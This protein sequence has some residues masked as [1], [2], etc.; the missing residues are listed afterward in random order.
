MSFPKIIVSCVFFGSCLLATHTL[1]AET[2]GSLKTDPSPYIR[3]HADDPIHW[4]VISQKVLQEAQQ[5]NRPV[6]ISSGYHACYWCYRMKIDTFSNKQLASIIND[7]F[8]PVLIDREV[9]PFIDQ[10][11]QAFMEEQRGFGGWPLTVILTPQG[12]PVAGFT[13]LGAESFSQVLNQFSDEWKTDSAKIKQLAET[14]TEAR[15]KKALQQDQLL[16]HIDYQKLLLNF[17]RQISGAAD[18]LHGGFGDKE[19][20]PHVPQLNALLDI[21]SL[22]PDPSLRKFLQLTLDSLLAGALHD[23][24][25]G[26][27]FRYAGNRDW[28][29]PHYEQMLYTQALMGKLLIRAG[30]TFKKPEYV[31]AGKETLTDMVK[32]FKNEKGLYVSALS[33]VS[34]PDNDD[35]HLDNNGDEAGGYYLWTKTELDEL[36]GKHWQQKSIHNL[37]TDDNE[38]ILPKPIGHD[39]KSIKALLLKTREKRLQSYDDKKLLAWHGLVLSGLAYGAQLSPELADAGKALASKLMLLVEQQKLQ[40][41]MDINTTN[42]KKVSLNSLVYV[43]QGLVDWWQ[44]SGDTQALEDAQKLLL[45]ARQQFYKN[46]RWAQNNQYGLLPSPPTHAIA[47]SQLP[48]PTAI[49][50]SLAWAITDLNKPSSQSVLGKKAN[51]TGERLPQSIQKNAFFH[52][53]L[54]STVIARQWRLRNNQRNKLP[55]NNQDQQ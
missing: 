27:F 29:S 1:W 26:G 41:L 30:Q 46:D 42:R 5:S 11:L 35:R 36:L 4:H 14:A 52:A 20:F 40:D 2:S 34:V 12:N 32:R 21:Y 43:A 38:K 51:Q 39:H 10:Q 3:D 45:I 8:V 16:E 17:L 48:S 6:L 47:D 37:L 53:T 49:W 54:I 7:S 24:L 15:T 50:L 9:N 13:Y 33:A 28:S 31:L 55:L 44:V 22:N 18:D 25:A 19:K 23:Q